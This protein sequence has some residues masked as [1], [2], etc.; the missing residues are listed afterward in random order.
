MQF[1]DG[2]ATWDLEQSYSATI[3]NCLPAGEYLLRIQQLGIHNPW[4][5]GI[6][7]FYISCAQIKVTGSGSTSPSPTVSIPGAFKETDPGYTVNIYNNFSNY[8]VPGPDVFTC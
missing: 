8:T 3:P 2:Q 7:Q 6:P 5:A 4:P 1:S